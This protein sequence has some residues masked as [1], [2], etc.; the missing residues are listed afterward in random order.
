MRYSTFVDVKSEPLSDVLRKVLEGVSTVSIH[1]DKPEVRMT[2][3]LMIR[4]IDSTQICIRTLYH[5]LAQLETSRE[6]SGVVTEE[7]KPHLDLL[8][9]YLHTYFESILRTLPRLLKHGEITYDLLWALFPPMTTVYSVCDDSEQERCTVLDSIQEMETMSKEKYFHLSTYFIDYNG[10]KFGKVFQG[11]KIPEFT[12]VKRIQSLD[13]FPLIYHEKV[14]EVKLALINRGRR[15]VSL[16]AVHHCSYSG[17]AHV[18]R[19]HPEKTLKVSTKGRLMVDPLSFKEKNPSY[20]SPRRGVRAQPVQGL[21]M[22]FEGT[23]DIVRDS[24]NTTS[25]PRFDV[26]F[27]PETLEDEEYVICSPTVFGFSLDKR[28]WGGSCPFRFMNLFD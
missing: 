10:T 22:D 16:P 20:F 26:N 23:P 8:I 3:I 9:R 6:N 13:A 17:L 19:P 12:G 21:P 11:L 1:G 24:S 5:Y 27:R 4:Y 18:K 7:A 28:V 2:T 15:Y 14:A 25:I